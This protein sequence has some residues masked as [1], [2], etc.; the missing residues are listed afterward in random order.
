MLALCSA[1]VVAAIPRA[2]SQGMY[3]DPGYQLAAA[4]QH[5]R[6]ESPSANTLV[7]RE[8]ADLSKPHHEWITWW[9][10]GTTIAAYPLLATGLSAGRAL[11]LI[12]IACEILGAVG[13]VA[14]FAC[15]GL[16]R[17]VIFLLAIFFPWVH[18][19][20]N[21][22]FDYSA[23][24]LLFGLM[25][26]LFVGASLVAER[27]RRD[28]RSLSLVGFLIGVA[29]GF[30]YVVKYSALLATLGAVAFLSLVA[31]YPMCRGRVRYVADRIAPSSWGSAGPGATS[32]GTS[33]ARAFALIAGFGLPVVVLNLANR[34]HA[35]HANL[36]SESLGRH[37][38]W[39]APL[40][41]LAS[42]ALMLADADGLLRY[43]FLHPA[44]PIF[45]SPDPLLVVAFPAGLILAWLVVHRRAEDTIALLTQCV[46]I[47]S[48]LFIL[49]IWTISTGVSF[50][51]RHVAT[52]GMISLPL[53]LREGGHAWNRSRWLARSVLAA[54]GFGCVVAPLLYGVG[55]L[56]GKSRRLSA[57]Y[58][59]GSADLY[60]PLLA[61]HDLASCRQHL[62]QRPGAMKAVW[63]LTEPMS[64]LDLDVPAVIEHADF[65]LTDV[66]RDS[67]AF[68]TS[69]RLEFY[70]LL[71][72][73]FEQNGKADVIRAR[74]RGASEWQRTLVPDC[75]YVLW[76][77]S[78]EPG[79]K[80][81][82]GVEA[83]INLP[84][85]VNH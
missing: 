12:A 1:L 8:V 38:D 28:L 18:Y 9:A 14:W 32:A 44:H 42:P 58:V 69:R 61:P 15:F 65:V 75:N 30:A 70:L 77:A 45:A 56:I 64:E 34:W 37:A 10:P 46:F 5:L 3:S 13:W 35:S 66:L 84:R 21:G 82:G 85:I 47:T 72:P 50:E 25:P 7:T 76:T 62:L 41:A 53:A 49:M 43:V 19:G 23:E 11:R 81:S 22:M 39:R 55:G 74:A 29:L 52:A 40:Y 26:W 57:S 20:W 27:W 79:T 71:P 24:T 73:H 78:L 36:I 2:H 16:P 54:M 67:P 83:G 59:T 80:D 63:Y 51:A 31:L 60:N 48:V 4:Q 6:G 68:A 17:P 33:I